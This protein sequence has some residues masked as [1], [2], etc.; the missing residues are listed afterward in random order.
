MYSPCCPPADIGGHARE[1]RWAG[2]PDSAC[3]VNSV[4]ARPAHGPCSPNG[5]IV[6]I[7]T[8]G[9]ARS[10]SSRSTTAAGDH[11]TTSNVAAHAQQLVDVGAGRRVD[12]DGVL[13]AGEP[14][15]QWTRAVG[16]DVG[17]GRAPRP[18]RVAARRVDPC[19]VDA[20]R[21]QQVGRVRAA[22]RRRQVQH[23]KGAVRV[24]HRRSPLV[25]VGH[26]GSMYG[27]TH[28][29]SDGVTGRHGTLGGRD[30]DPGGMD[31]DDGPS[32]AAQRRA[33]RGDPRPACC[34]TPVPSSRSAATARR[35]S[36]TSSTHR[37]SRGARSTSTSSR[38]GRS[39]SP[40]CTACAPTSSRGRCDR[41]RARAR[42]AT[43]SASPSSSTSPRTRRRR[44]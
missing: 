32:H 22:E 35:A 1:P 27:R 36:P 38:S 5:V 14:L 4:A 23:P 11:S 43:R 10:S 15:E 25:A 41:W 33:H 29:D 28:V 21:R 20:A 13:P 31:D 9:T 16:R 12:R 42:C 37:G 40:S 26:L 6:T 17:T 8:S 2:A 3:S 39:S 18:Q 7:V 24:G 19:D 34:A 44:A 30:H